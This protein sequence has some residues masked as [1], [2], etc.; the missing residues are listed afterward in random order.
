M[1]AKIKNLLSKNLVISYHSHCRGS[2]ITNCN[3][4]LRKETD[5]HTIRENRK[6]A[7]EE[8]CSFVN[9][10]IV[11]ENNSYFLSFL[12]MLY[13]RCLNAE[14][15]PLSNLQILATS[16]YIEEK[17]VKTFPEKIKVIIMHRTKIVAPHDKT[18]ED[19]DF[20]TIQNNDTVQRA[21]LILREEIF[22][23]NPNEVS[24]AGTVKDAVPKMLQH[25][26]TTLLN[27]SNHLLKPSSDRQRIVNSYTEDVIYAVSD[28]EIKPAKHVNL[29]VL[30]KNLSDN[31]DVINA[32]NR[33]G[34]CC[35][36][37]YI[38]DIGKSYNNLIKL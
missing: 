25:F 17:L 1:L 16:R 36:Y 3:T 2:Y 9:D 13:L 4:A 32:V 24:G 19:N 29:G 37:K 7:Y 22:K 8:I 10:V 11:G 18:L 5:W 33:Y 15:D 23:I 28:G 35:D 6:R 27:D 31:M 26:Y 21:A 12:E 30:L 14:R 34:H 20:D 38:K